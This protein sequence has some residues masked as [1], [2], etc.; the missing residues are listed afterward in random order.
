MRLRP[1]SHKFSALVYFSVCADFRP[2]NTKNI[3]KK[4]G[5]NI[6]PIPRESL[7]LHSEIIMNTLS[8]HI[9]RLLLGHNCV[10]VPSFGGFV[11]QYI[12]ARYVAEDQL[13]LPP[14][15]DVCFNPLLTINDG[16]LV[17]SYM[18]A[19][20]ETYAQCLSAI[21]A[22]VADIRA[23]LQADGNVEFAGIGT[24]ESDGQSAYDF[25]PLES[26]I[27]SPT[28]YAL[29]SV[30][31][32]PRAEAAQAPQAVLPTTPTT[33]PSEPSHKA[34]DNVYIIR[35]N[36]T[37]AHSVAA[38][39]IALLVCFAWSSPLGDSLLRYTAHIASTT[40]SKSSSSDTNIAATM[41]QQALDAIAHKVAASVK[42]KQSTASPT[43]TTP[44]PTEEYVIVLASGVTERNATA[45]VASLQGQGFDNLRIVPMRS[46]KG[47]RVV[48]GSYPN[49]QQAQA[50]LNALCKQSDLEGVWVLK[51]P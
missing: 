15:R 51:M 23:R 44:A 6:L 39:I 18:A 28:L 34:D 1:F 33:T 12:P 49:A 3:L 14:Y 41:P 46:G 10:I 37:L 43:T 27:A 9:E 7:T 26:G 5:S 42:T 13:F 2:D 38:A 4:I 35:I 29:D 11:A 50:H 32:S 30:A 24:L 19:T 48:Q 31:A 36:K 20:G 25:H 21:D 8:R 16:L 40:A 22:A 47:L 45:F 17:Q